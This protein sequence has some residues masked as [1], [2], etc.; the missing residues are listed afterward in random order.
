MRR[1]E[2]RLL[3]TADLV[4]TGGLSL[5]RSIEGRHANAHC[6]PSS[7]EADHFAQAN[8]GVAE[9]ADQAGI[10]H[11]RLG[12]FGVVDERMD[13]SVVRALAEAHP[14]W[15]VVMV[16]P[17]VKVDPAEGA[18]LAP[19]KPDGSG[20]PS[21]EALRTAEALAPRLA[22]LAGASDRRAFPEQEVEAL[23]EAGL[24]TAPLP[25]A[26][27]GAGLGREPGT[28]HT[29]Y[30]VLRAVGRG[31][32][33]VGRLYKGHLGALALIGAY[34][35]AEQ[36]AA[37]FADARA[38]H[39]FGVCHADDARGVR[40]EPAGSGG[41]RVE[42]A[43][44]FCSGAGGVTRALINGQPAGRG[45]GWQLALVPLDETEATVEPGWWPAEG[46][47]ASVSGRADFSGV[48][49]GPEALVGTPG[50]CVREPLFT[51]GAVRF[52]A[53][54][55]GGAEALFAATAEALRR[56]YRLGDP[57]Q[58]ARLGEMA[59]ALETGALWLLGAARLFE[60]PDASAASQV[61]Y[62]QMTRTAV[63]RVCLDVLGLAD[64]CLGARGLLLPSPVER[65]GR[66]LRLYLRQ[67]GPDGMLTA[68]GRFAATHP[69]RPLGAEVR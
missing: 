7:V 43:K 28:L 26:E 4:F 1:N 63:E 32:L 49:L 22:A 52:C 12:Y 61:A 29:L 51:G 17:V 23:R 11:P 39:L 9:P 25:S 24:L 18:R 31:S 53:V 44:V 15:Q 36:R 27:G 59:T 3:E 50:D 8:D 56:L 67:P 20:A 58:Q 55:L 14:E 47:R 41:V 45:G 13:L 10:P 2:R 69:A 30:G 62:A 6:F 48:T 37:A 60:R 65:I 34:G 38:G 33:P 64:R 54:W 57:F 5:H 21:A 16:G 42:G 68:A 35:D 19:A 46:M 66:D 40:F